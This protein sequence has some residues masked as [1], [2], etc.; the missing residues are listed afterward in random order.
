MEVADDSP[1]EQ[2][3]FRGPGQAFLAVARLAS[4][5]VMAMEPSDDL[6]TA[7][8]R[9]R[10]TTQL[11]AAVL[12]TM[13]PEELPLLEETAEEYFADPGAALESRR[14]DE[15]LGF[16]LSAEL[17][18]PYVLAV[19]TAAVQFLAAT[20]G[21]QLKH[22]LKPRIEALVSR[23]CGGVQEDDRQEDPGPDIALNRDQARQLRKLT[24]TQA[25]AAGM[26]EEQAEL[27]A[28]AVVGS[29]VVAGDGDGP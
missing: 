16:G 17:L 25:R 21:G 4:R 10:L 1:H 26:T 18:S 23:L 22:E 19:A 28:D 24:L 11:T 20:I 3:A 6:L 2:G 7:S 13:A 29:V 8:A 15:P 5:G 9:Q 12:R 14:Q 27:L